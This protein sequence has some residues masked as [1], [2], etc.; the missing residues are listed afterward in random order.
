MSSLYVSDSM[1]EISSLIHKLV[2]VCEFLKAI[3]R[4]NF[5]C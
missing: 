1:Y 3:D 4:L 2:L 5:V